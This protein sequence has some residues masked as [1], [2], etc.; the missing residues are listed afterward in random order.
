MKYWDAEELACQI[1]GLDYDALVDDGREDE[2]EEGIYNKFE[3]S[4]DQ[5]TDVAS[6]LLKLT[7]LVKSDLTGSLYHAFGVPEG[8]AWRAIT[9]EI[10]NY[11][12]F[13]DKD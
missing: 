6:A 1:L 4:M 10:A 3:I 8:D 5:F 11:K 9:K 13:T 12:S 2:I 7:P